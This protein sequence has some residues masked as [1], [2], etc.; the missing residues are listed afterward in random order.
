MTPKLGE[1]TP[2]QPDPVHH[3]LNVKYKQY[4]KRLIE[5][6]WHIYMKKTRKTY[7]GLRRRARVCVARCGP[8]TV[9]VS[10]DRRMREWDG[11]SARLMISV[12]CM[13]N[14][15]GGEVLMR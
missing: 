2:A 12:I 14:G 10:N 5:P 9:V 1:R 15:R 7:C 3:S 11:Y 8:V 13:V 4:S 6:L